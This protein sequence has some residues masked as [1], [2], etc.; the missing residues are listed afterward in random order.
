MKF[1]IALVCLSLGLV[2]AEL[3]LPLPADIQAR[4]PWLL[5][6]AI[7][8]DADFVKVV[9]GTEVASGEAKHQIAMLRS[10]SFI[11]GGSL[12][13]SNVVLVCLLKLAALKPKF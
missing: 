5:H 1:T 9:G 12:I 7:N 4:Y 8:S 10:G 13:A 3:R 11:C 2:S 6:E